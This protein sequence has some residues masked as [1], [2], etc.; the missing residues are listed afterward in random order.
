MSLKVLI[1]FPKGSQSFGF[2]YMNLL[3]VKLPSRLVA[4][5]ESVGSWKWGMR[6]GCG[7]IEKI[8]RLLFPPITVADKQL[9]FRLVFAAADRVPFVGVVWPAVGDLQSCDATGEAFIIYLNL[10]LRIGKSF[11]YVKLYVHKSDDKTCCLEADP[12]EACLTRPCCTDW[13]F[14]CCCCCCCR[15]FIIKPLINSNECFRS[16]W[17]EQAIINRVQL[18]ADAWKPISSNRYELTR[19]GWFSR[20]PSSLFKQQ[21]IKMGFVFYFKTL[22][23]WS[24][25]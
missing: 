10:N 17:V 13:G 14:I 16:Y 1:H 24:P 11:Y 7:L 21:F 9:L 18:V 5:G 2:L 12:D 3:R 25:F 23:K 6:G 20:F 4:W 8:L 15:S 22:S 19:L